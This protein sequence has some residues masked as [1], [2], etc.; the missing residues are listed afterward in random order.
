MAQLGNG[1]GNVQRHSALLWCSCAPHSL[2]YPSFIQTKQPAAIHVPSCSF[3]GGTSSTLISYKLC[4]SVV[5]FCSSAPNVILLLAPHCCGGP[6]STISQTLYSNKKGAS[7]VESLHLWQMGFCI[8]ASWQTQ[9]CWNAAQSF[10]IGFWLLS[11]RI[12]LLCCLCPN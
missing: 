3:R 10:L 4:Y 5:L 2:A 1:I 8:A 12:W 7:P 11:F 9:G 6:L